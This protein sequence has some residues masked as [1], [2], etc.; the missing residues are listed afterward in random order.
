M[1]EG[2]TAY[3]LDHLDR[4]Q[5]DPLLPQ[6]H[7]QCFGQYDAAVGLLGQVGELMGQASVVGNGKRCQP[8]PCLQF[9]QMLAT[10]LRPLGILRPDVRF[11]KQLPS[12]H[13]QQRRGGTASVGR[14]KPG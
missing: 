3:A 7:D 8:H 1:R 13:C 12:N 9:H 2:L 11:D 14:T 4:R 10:G 5:D 6:Q